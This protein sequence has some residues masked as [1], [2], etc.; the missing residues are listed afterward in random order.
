MHSLPPSIS[1]PLSPSPSLPPSPS[2]LQLLEMERERILELGSTLKSKST[3]QDH[4]EGHNRGKRDSVAGDLI[5]S[6]SMSASVQDMRSIG[7]EIQD[8]WTLSP[9]SLVGGK[10]K[11]TDRQYV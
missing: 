3:F 9:L 8:A 6:I 11:Q 5:T 7:S 2:L 10:G 1:P 4:K